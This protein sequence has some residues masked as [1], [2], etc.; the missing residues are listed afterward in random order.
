MWGIVHWKQLAIFAALVAVCGILGAGVGAFF[1]SA[2]WGSTAFFGILGC[3]GLARSFYL[4]VG[5]LIVGTPT[6]V[7]LGVGKWFD[8]GVAGWLAFLGVIAIASLGVS[9]MKRS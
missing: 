6:L 7:A 4:F 3:I 9:R 5:V 8:S 1:H 2:L